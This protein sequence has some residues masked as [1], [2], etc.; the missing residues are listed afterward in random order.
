MKGHKEDHHRAHKN[1]GGANEPEEDLKV[2]NQRYTYQSKVNDEAEERKRGGKVG[3]K[4][5][6][7]HHHHSCKC[8]KC[9]GGR[10][11]RK[12][13]GHVHHEKPE[14]LKH[15]KHVGHVEGAMAK[16]HAGRMPRKSGGRTG[17]DEHPYSSARK[18]ENPPGRKTDME[19]E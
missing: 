6:D 15:A 8:H 5:G 19:L 7:E 14:H 13:G 3:M 2:K 1:T 11:E 16:H 17:S 10:V 4:H 12:A 18:G 9:S